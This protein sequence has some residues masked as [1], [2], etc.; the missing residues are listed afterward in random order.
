M[1]VVLLIWL[2]LLFFFVT[3]SP[4]YAAGEV[5]TI[6]M[7]PGNFEPKD[8]QIKTGEKVKF[9]NLDQVDRWPA[10]NIHPTHLIYP[11]FDPKKAIAPGFSWQ[12]KFERAGTFKFHDHLNPALAGTIIVEGSDVKEGQ[13]PVQ[14]VSSLDEDGGGL[15]LLGGDFGDGDGCAFPVSAPTEGRR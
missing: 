1:K 8:L 13:K 7:T 2:T 15:R 6:K 4:I 11:E 5:I 12:F 10:S 3:T 9:E 14:T